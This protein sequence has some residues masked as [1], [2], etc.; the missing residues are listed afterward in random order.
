MKNSIKINLIALVLCIT[1]TISLFAQNE[2]KTLSPY[3]KIISDFEGEES[4][5]LKSTSAEVSISG[6]V[7]NVEIAQVYENTGAF[8][9]EA[10][11]VFP[12]STRAAVY[13]MEMRLDG[14][15]IE[16]VIQRKGEAQ[17]TYA[18]A[19]KEGKRAS[20]LEQERPNV[21]T[22]SVANIIPGDQI[23]VILRYTETIVPVAGVYEFVYPTVVGPRYTGEQEGKKVVAQAVAYTSEET[24]PTYDFDIA[25]NVNAGL[26]IADITCKTHQTT[27]TYSDMST[28]QVQLHPSETK[29]G[30][31]DFVL[32]YTLSG[33]KINTGLLLHEGE[34]ENHFMLT[35]QPPKS[36]ELRDI[37][38]REYLFVVDVSGSMHGFPLDVTKKLM[39]NLMSN[40][41]HDDKFNLL[42]FASAS[43]MYSEESVYAN[44]T[45]VENAIQMMSNQSGGGGT[46]LMNALNRVM[47]IPKCEDGLSRSVVVITDG[48]ISV[49]KEVYD[50]IRKS[51]GEFNFYSFGIG[52]SVNRYLIEGI[53]NVGNTEPL[54]VKDQAEANQKAEKFRKFISAPVLTDINIDWG[55]FDVYDLSPAKINDV[56]AERPVVVTGKYRGKAKGE[57]TLKGVS[58]RENYKAVYNTAKAESDDSNSGIQYLWARNKIRLM[59]DYIKLDG[60]DAQ[61]EQVTQLGLKYNLL[62]NYTSFV[63]V[64][65]QE[66]VSNGNPQQIDQPVP[67]PK[68]VPSSAIAN[69]S[70][71]AFNQGGVGADLMITNPLSGKLLKLAYEVTA[72]TLNT[73]EVKFLEMEISKKI[74]ELIKEFGLEKVRAV[75]LEIMID[76]RGKVAKLEMVDSNMDRALVLDLLHHIEKWTFKFRKGENT[77]F[78]LSID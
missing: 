28:G 51:N 32:E 26:P 43:N 77:R 66:I 73:G 37:P 48:Y 21:F 12:A 41:R 38:Q 68:E 49:E 22:M 36:V 33:A 5:P 64:D 27:I 57:I 4:L 45:E 59:D 42:F 44:P 11:Y 35:V 18:A 30:N 39:R 13:D 74:D 72:P 16:A 69:S 58:G 67:L 52:S 10:V 25:V 20:L 63:A 2:D 46:R 31:R 3:F 7:A 78:V 56:L 55:D 8:P 40:L 24:A 76:I 53:A 29:G 34:H 61:I 15:I 50:L 70:T 54:F 60:N 23:E 65:N 71:Y 17:A 75:E 6:V 9:I 62:T 14:R 19:K 47:D 1:S